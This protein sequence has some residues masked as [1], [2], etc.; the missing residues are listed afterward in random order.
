MINGR[1][2]ESTTALLI[3]SSKNPIAVAVS[4]SPRNSTTSTEP[5]FRSSCCSGLSRYG[6]SNASMPPSFWMSS[7]ASC[8]AMSSTS[9]TVTTPTRCPSVSVTGSMVRSYFRN[10][11]TARSFGSVAARR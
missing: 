4:I 11:S 2:S 3:S 6:M 9:S 7:V 10:I 1:K 8:S 5:R